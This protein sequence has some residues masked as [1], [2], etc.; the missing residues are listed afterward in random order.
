MKWDKG[1][2]PKINLVEKRE[3]VGQLIAFRVTQWEPVVTTRYGTT[4]VAEVEPNVLT[5]GFA[6]RRAARW[7]VAGAMARQMAHRP[8]GCV[9]CARVTSSVTKSETPGSASTSKSTLRRGRWRT[10]L[11]RGA[12]L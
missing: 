9:N 1:Y 6:G 4:Q 12:N 8:M 3:L 10:R 7:R 11:C 2:V 5:G